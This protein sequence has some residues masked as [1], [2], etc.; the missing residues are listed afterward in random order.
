MILVTGINGQLGHDVIKELTKRNI[1]CIGTSSNELDITNK[2]IVLDYIKKLKPQK[3]IHC[4]AYTAV[5][6]AEDDVAL[7]TQVNVNGSKNIT[8]ACSKIN[9]IMMYISTD[10]VFDGAGNTPFKT[11]DKTCPL[12]VYGETKLSGEVIVKE[13]LQDYFIVRISWLFGV[14]GNNFV[15]TMLQLGKEKSSLNVVSDQIG[16]PTYTKDLAKLLCDMIVTEKYG[17]Y[18]ATNEG[19]CSWAEFATKIMEKS[20]LECEINPISSSEYKTKATRPKNSK[21]DKNVLTANNFNLL[22][23]WEDALDRFLNEV[24]FN[25]ICK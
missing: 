12:G 17:V 4:A 20:N 16:S 9:A 14:N 13:M 24:N 5:D 23:H 18:H 15:K 6:Q 8:L 7:C 2:D 19:Y 3:I 1:K 10:Y 21:L 25:E 11:D 22:P